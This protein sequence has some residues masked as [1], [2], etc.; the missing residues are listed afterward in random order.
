MISPLT[1]ALKVHSF[2]RKVAFMH[3]PRVTRPKSI[4]ILWITVPSERKKHLV[5][6]LEEIPKCT[7]FQ[8]SF[9]RFY[10]K[11]ISVEVKRF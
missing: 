10:N 4:L 1:I 5:R 11:R 8:F 9:I 7:Y 2:I 6:A 3:A